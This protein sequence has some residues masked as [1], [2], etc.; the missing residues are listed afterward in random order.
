MLFG[1]FLVPTRRDVAEIRAFYDALLAREEDVSGENV[2]AAIRSNLATNE[3]HF[4]SCKF[5]AVGR[6]SYKLYF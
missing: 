2:S 1:P 4:W 6:I 5:G 3:D